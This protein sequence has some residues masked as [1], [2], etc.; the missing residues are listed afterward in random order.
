VTTHVKQACERYDVGKRTSL[1]IRTLFDGTISF[2]DVLGR[3][4]PPLGG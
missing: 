1:V 2:G 4:H 3:A